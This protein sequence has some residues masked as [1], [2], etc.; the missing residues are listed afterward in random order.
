MHMQDRNV[1]E[2]LHK[3]RTLL[4]DIEYLIADEARVL[5]EVLL[6]LMHIMK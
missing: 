2:A 5:V 3:I 6:S 4:E 1:F